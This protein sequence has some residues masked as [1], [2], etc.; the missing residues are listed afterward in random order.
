MTVSEKQRLAVDGT[1]KELLLEVR[2]A[3]VSFDMDRGKSKVLDDVS[4]DI[5]RD[6]IIGV[7][8]E[9]GSGKSMFASA[10]LNAVVNPGMLSGEI[11]YHPPDGE[12]Y[13]IREL[14]DQ[15]LKEFRWEE[16]SMVFQGAMDSFNPTMTIGGH[17]EETLYAHNY[18]IKDGMDHGRQLLADLYLDPERVL[19]SYPHELSGGMAQR[20]LIALSLLLKPN[21]LVMD[22]P[23]AALDLLMQRSI[24]SLLS[25]IH[26]EY[27][28]TVVF[29][30]H[31]LPL[32]ADLADRLA[33]MYAFQFVEIG[34][35]H[36]ILKDAAH[37]YT[38]ALLKAVP[39]LAASLDEMRPIDGDSPDPVDTPAGCSYHTRCPF[40]DEQCV[41]STPSFRDV[42]G[43]DEGWDWNAGDQRPDQHR[44]ACYHWKAA[45]EG[46]PYTLNNETPEMM[47]DDSK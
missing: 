26:K 37:P 19:G 39:N 33:V 29:I 34:P 31:D 28:I 45:R 41:E 23:T 1:Q 32:V 25:K 47:F 6:E 4:M 27:D 2:N 13:N 16:I 9:S 36:D 7:V 8:G 21:V 15:E 18:N 17:F 44:V 40:A 43:Q 20:A 22:E 38:R 35:C 10:L 30:T 11:I 24:T 5:Y 46:L 14:S 12:P 42:S 3:S